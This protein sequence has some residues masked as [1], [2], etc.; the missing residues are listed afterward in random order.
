M[1]NLPPYQR[2]RIKICG[3]K[4]EE[5]VDFAVQA[6]VDAV[7]FVLY[8]FSHRYVPLERAKSLS[9]RLPAFVTPVL[10]FVNPNVDD[11]L[12]AT[13]EIGHAIIQLH[14]DESPELCAEIATATMRP[15]IRAARI[16]LGEDAKNFDLIQYCNQY[17]DA[18]ALLLDAQVEGYGGG[19]QTFQWSLLPPNVN[20]HLVLSGGLDA[21]NVAEGIAQL[22]HCGKSLSVDV[23]TGVERLN[24]LGQPIKGSKD[25]ERITQFI[26]AVRAADAL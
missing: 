2:T 10:L 7:G 4:S 1:N 5:D 18:H 24:S 23:S 25:P 12:S 22:R 15:Y 3:L 9:R 21:A 14:G 8:P 6:G 26:A 16:P 19:G 17:P 11:V 13:D 20:A